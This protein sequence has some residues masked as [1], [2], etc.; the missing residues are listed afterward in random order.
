M[1][2]PKDTKAYIH[3]ETLREIGIR[4]ARLGFPKADLFRLLALVPI[5][6]LK[7]LAHRYLA[8]KKR[9]PTKD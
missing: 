2:E 3:K 9:H 5:D 8:T 1:P 7:D 6:I 4:A